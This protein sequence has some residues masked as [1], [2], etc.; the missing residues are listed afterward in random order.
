MELAS[1]PVVIVGIPVERSHFCQLFPPLPILLASYLE[2][3]V[4][5]G[6]FSFDIDVDTTFNRIS[7][8]VVVFVGL[9]CEFD[10]PIMSVVLV[11]NAI[12]L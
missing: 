12:A 3:Y 4:S 8:H 7:R 11:H 6:S 5:I 9:E 2:N 1:R 10:I